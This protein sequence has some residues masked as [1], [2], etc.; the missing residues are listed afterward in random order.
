V[1]VRRVRI[2]LVEDEA[3]IVNLIKQGLEEA[4]LYCGRGARWA[5]RPLD[6]RLSKRTILLL[7]DVI[8]AR[9]G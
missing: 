3:G 2:L 6:G 5:D 9:N 4:Q 7:L 1:E 8:A